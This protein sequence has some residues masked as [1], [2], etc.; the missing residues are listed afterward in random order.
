[1]MLDEN[2]DLWDANDVQEVALAW[3]RIGEV[4][5]EEADVVEYQSDEEDDDLRAE[6]DLDVDIHGADDN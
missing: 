2:S 3:K 1:M 6:I 5:D 4:A